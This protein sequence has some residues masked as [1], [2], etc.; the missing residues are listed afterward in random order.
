MEKDF[1]ITLDGTTLLVDLDY[2][3]STANASRF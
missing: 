1:K 2:E 3:L